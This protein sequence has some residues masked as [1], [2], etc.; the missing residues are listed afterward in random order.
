MC[1][2]ICTDGVTTR[3][4]ICEPVCEPPRVRA[5]RTNLSAELG[6]KPECEIKCQDSGC[7][8]EG[9]PTC[10]IICKLPPPGYRIEAQTV[11]CDWHCEHPDHEFGCQSPNC[12]PPTT[13]EWYTVISNPPKSSALWLWILLITVFVMITIFLPARTSLW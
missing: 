1:H 3:N 6:Y 4:R 7:E 12:I 5:V 9:C 13:D 8:M 2:P 11:R 10:S